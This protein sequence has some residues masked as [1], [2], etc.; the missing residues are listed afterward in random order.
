MSSGSS[1]V[2]LSS[3]ASPGSRSPVSTA[4]ANADD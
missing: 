4:L 1:L 3:P 2:S